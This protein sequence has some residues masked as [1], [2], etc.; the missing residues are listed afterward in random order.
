MILFISFS[1]GHIYLVWKHET[2]FF[3]TFI[4]GGLFEA[5]GYGARAVNA[6]EAPNY[7][8]MPYAMQSLFILLGPSVCGFDLYDPR[9]NRTSSGWRFQITHSRNKIDQDLRTG[10]CAVVFYPEWR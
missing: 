4:V 1:F 8:T 7:G 9:S 5:V 6:N 2:K 10:R 3:V